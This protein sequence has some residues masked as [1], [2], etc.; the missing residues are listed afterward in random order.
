MISILTKVIA[1]FHSQPDI[2]KMGFLSSFFKV[3]PDSFTDSEYADLDE[4]YD[5]EELA[6]AV[7]DLDTNAVMLIDDKFVNKQIPFPVYAMK[8]PVKISQ[9]MTRQPGKSAY[10]TDRVNWL[11]KLANILVRKLGRMTNMIRRSMEEQ[12]AQVLQTGDIFL[13]DEKGNEAFKL[14]LEPSMSHFPTVTIPWSDVD[15]ADPLGDMDVLSDLIRDEGLVDVKN[16]L[17]GRDAWANF[18]KNK[19]VQENLRRDGLATGELSPKLMGL[20]AK[21]HGYID[22]NDNRYYFWTYNARYEIFGG[23]DKIRYI[24][25]KNVILLPDPEEL[26]FRAIFGGIPAVEPDQ[27]VFQQLFGGDKI[28]IDGKYDFKPRAWWSNDKGAWWTEVKSR[29]LM[30]PVSVKRYGCIKTEIA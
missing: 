16:A 11:A 21:H 28:Q 6:P 22:Y 3:T 8:S 25:P 10:V 30:L 17:F 19:F 29:P 12:A 7:T 24:D 27:T 5:G 1:L 20:G 26:D 15:H 4:I 13:T 9:L 23:G 18:I 2:T 14:G